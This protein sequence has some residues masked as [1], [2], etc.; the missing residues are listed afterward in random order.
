MGRC[1]SPCLG[2]LD[3]NLY[4]RRLDQALRLFVDGGDGG[5][6]LIAHVDSQMREAA[7]S[8]RYERA[9]ALRRR[10]RRLQVILERLGGAVEATH[11]RPRLIIAAHPTD[12]GKADVFWLAAGRLVDFGSLPP[13]TDELVER[14]DA[15]IRRGGRRGEL[16]AHLPPDEIDEVRIVA[17]YL[18]SHPDTSQLHLDLAPDTGRLI[19]FAYAAA[20]GENGSSTTSAVVP[21]GPTDTVAPGSASRRRRARAIGPSS[22]DC[23]TLEMFPTA[24]SPSVI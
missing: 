11:A 24:F 8:R 5:A 10:A 15:A 6:K 1:L 14:T 3:P 22:G 20:G 9:S 12:G 23:A 13:G 4:R 19:E 18:A 21:W 7:E 2:D 17:T 16:G